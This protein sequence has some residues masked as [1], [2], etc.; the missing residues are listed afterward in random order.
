MW[1]T[2][3][4]A[5]GVVPAGGFVEPG[6]FHIENPAAKRR[7]HG[8]LEVSG[9]LEQ[10][11]LIRPREATEEEILRIHGDKYIHNLK[12]MSDQGYGDAGEKAVVGPSS[13][14]IACLAAGGCI[15][16]SDAI[17]NGTIRNAYALVRP[18]GHHA[19]RD[20]GRGF[21]LLSNGTI[22]V[23][24]LRTR[25][26]LKRI[27]IVDWDAHHGN[28]AQQIYYTDPNVLTVSIH[29]ESNYPIEGGTIDKN[30]EG[31]GLGTN[32]NIPL[33]PGSGHQ[34]HLAAI[35]QVVCPSLKLFRPEMIIISCGFD[36][37]I[38]DPLARQ[39]TMAETFRLMTRAIMKAADQ[40]CDG[41][42]LMIHEG[43][44]AEFYTPFCG[45]AVM[46]ELSG[47]KTDVEDPFAHH[48]NKSV[49]L[50]QPHQATVLEQAKKLLLNVPTHND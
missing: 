8:L 19:E 49:Q 25:H 47:I 23:E 32:I 20:R 17:I 11:S 16:A 4:I 34:T 5:A 35:E 39:M 28:G 41:R 43:G 45:L 27:A 30:G 7:I 6:L 24:H 50:L 48:I 31:D 46:E 14:P 9:L 15:V 22:T 13:W 18:A 36:S 42:L 26:N 38:F 37:C 1:H 33:P 40:L 10:L 29:E 44:Y 3:G 2:T 21:C 12:K